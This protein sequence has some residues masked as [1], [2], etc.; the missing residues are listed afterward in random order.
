MRTLTLLTIAFLSTTA[1]SQ[2]NIQTDMPVGPFQS[3]ELRHGGHVTLRHGP[4]QRVTLL[5][6]DPQITRARIEDGQ[7]LVI[8]KCAAKCPRGYRMEV[9]VVTPSLSAV[10]VSNGGL[11][12]TAGDFPAQAAIEA[13]V[14]QGGAVDIRSI[15]VDAVDAEVYSGGRIFTNA[16]QTLTATV[17]SGGAITY[18]GGAR[19]RKS[20]RDGGVV[21]RGNPED[22]RRPLSDLGYRLAP[23]VPPVPPM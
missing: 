15:A 22:A 20:V 4:V 21:A 7:R 19:V 9:E 23:P 16:R 14:E 8:Q 17:E 1:L 3:V 13:N 10:A 5:S 2:T 12:Q 11:L 18:W 6:G